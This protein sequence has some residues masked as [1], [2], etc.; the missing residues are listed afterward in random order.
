M[1]KTYQI[2]VTLLFVIYACSDDNETF[3]DNQV[4]TIATDSLNT[5]IKSEIIVDFN[6]P[7]GTYWQSKFIK[8]FGNINQYSFDEKTRHK[9]VNSSLV[10]KLLRDKVGQEGGVIS[11]VF[12]E[13]GTE[14]SLEYKV[15]FQLGFQW[16]KGGKL[17]GVGGGKVYA[18][19]DSAVAGDGWSFRPVW[20]FYDGVN[21]SK[22]FISPY[23]YYVDQPKT[24][25]DELSKRFTIQE[26]TWYTIFIQV[27]MNTN[28]NND[29]LL[30]M[31][32]NGSTFYYNNS[33]RWVTK[34]SGRE[35]DEIMWD[36]F[37]GGEG[38]EYIATEDNV[39]I[40]DDFVLRKL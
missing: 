33:F 29:G 14:Y 26:D 32:I 24:F 9:I 40:F 7:D 17:P 21:N 11:D 5:S 15:K 20:Q 3:I 22:P 28:N 23:A 36:I 35:I 39:I 1:N 18:G 38:S 25:G 12:I 37:R 27:K 13:T 6:Q 30:K 10:V 4:D 8:D 2:L 31:S 16:A 19:G 34:D